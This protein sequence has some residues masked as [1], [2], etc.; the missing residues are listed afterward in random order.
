M[1]ALSE[2]P[3]I[4]GWTASRTPAR[5]INRKYFSHAC[6]EKASFF[7]LLVWSRLKIHQMPTVMVDIRSCDSWWQR[8][9]EAVDCTHE[10]ASSFASCAR[11]GLRGSN[12][13]SRLFLSLDAHPGEMARRWRGGQV[14]PAS[15]LQRSSARATP[16]AKSP[17][18]RPYRSQKYRD[19][20][21]GTNPVR[22]FWTR[23][24]MTLRPRSNS[25]FGIPLTGADRAVR[26]RVRSCFS[27]VRGRWSPKPRQAAPW[28]SKWNSCS[29]S[30]SSLYVEREFS[31]LDTDSQ[32]ILLLAFR[33]HQPQR[34]IAQIARC[35]ERA[36][37]YKVPAALAQ[38]ARLL[39]RA[40]M[41]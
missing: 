34:V 28:L 1:L 2:D 21:G 35:S 32:T 37:A 13:A 27:P 11:V 8:N 25:S 16:R 22:R 6:R 15:A 5:G 17:P 19:V 23:L 31:K 24:P 7:P 3:S 41:L 26:I 29:G 18:R 10:P 38:L 4:L 9:G 20:R 36:V 14:Y 33:E 39:D 30:C 40:S 12:G